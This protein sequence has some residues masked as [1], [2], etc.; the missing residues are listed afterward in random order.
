MS[1]PLL[2]DP[3]IVTGPTRTGTGNGTLSIDKLTHFTVAQTYTLTCIGKSPDTIFSVVASLDGPVGIATVGI[4]FFDQELKIFLTLQ[5]GSTAFEVG[6]QFVV[7]VANGT[8]LNQD[9]IDL[10]DELP[11][12]NFGTGI[13]GQSKGDHN[14]RYSDTAVAAYAY[15]QGLKFLAAT[16]GSGGNSLQIQALEPVPGT[17]ASLVIQDL[18]YTAL[19]QDASGNAITIEYA[20]FTPAV[21]ATATIQNLV[22]QYRTAGTTGNTS[23]V[24]YVNDGT[25]GSETC[26]LVGQALTVHIQSG[27][28]TAAQIQAAVVANGPVN[29]AFQATLTGGSTGAE[30][31]VTNAQVFL[32][33][34]AAAIGD[35]GNEV[36]QVTGNAIKVI[37]QNAASTASGIRTKLLA[38]SAAMALVSVAL[39][40]TGSNFE[41]IPTVPTHLAG[42]LDGIGQAG[43]ETCQV[44]GNLIKLYFQSGKSTATAVRNSFNAVSAATTLASC[45]LIG[46]GTDAMYSPVTAFNF[47]GGLTKF[48]A[49]NQH[50]LT[51]A[52]NFHEGNASVKTQDL[53]VLGASN[54]EGHVKLDDILS[55]T[56]TANSGPAVPNAQAYINRL[57]QLG[58]ISIRTADGSPV[59]Y[60]SG[61]LIFTADLRIDLRDSAVINTVAVSN[62]PISLT[63]GQSIYLTLNPS[64]SYNLTPVVA[65]SVDKGIFVLR[66]ATRV[67]SSLIWFNGAVQADNDIARI[68]AQVD[69]GP[70]VRG[71]ITGGG[72]VSHSVSTVGTIAWDGPIVLKQ[73]GS[74]QQ[75]SIAAGNVALADGDVAYISLDDPFVTATKTLQV[76]AISTF[77][78]SRVDRYWLFHR[79]GNEVHVRNGG[80]LVPGEERPIGTPMSADIYGFIGS[81]GE[82]DHSPAYSS[83]DGATTSN[84]Y[85]TDGDSLT[86]SIK[87]LD[88]DLAAEAATRASADSSEAST[89]AAADTAETAAR[90][91]HEADTTTHGTTGDIVGTS[92]TQVLT[93]KDID[94]GTASNAR[95]ITIPK[96]TFANLSALTRKQGTVLYA[97]DLNQVYYDD[98]TN[99]RPVG[100]GG[101][102][103]PVDALDSVSTTLPTVS[104]GL[105][106][107]GHTVANGDYIL[108]TALTTPSQNNRIYKAVI[109]GASVSWTLQT[110]GQNTDG[111]PKTGDAA[112]VKSGTAY[113]NVLF[114]FDGSVWYDY[115]A[116]KSAKRD[117]SNLTTTAVNQ[118]LLPASHNTKDLG[119]DSVR[120]A[121]MFAVLAYATTRKMGS[122]ARNVEETYL[123]GQTLTG[124]GTSIL[125]GLTFD[126]TIYKAFHVD[127]TIYDPG[128]GVRRTGTLYIVADGAAGSAGTNASVADTGAYTGDAGVTWTAAMSGNICQVSYTATSGNKTMH[129]AVKKF[130]G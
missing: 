16:A 88:T 114:A 15:L 106:V 43:S 13:K 5:Q 98:G 100:S 44:S 117:L 77:D 2:K 96:D 113:G 73:M 20:N 127:Y 112:Y 14:V 3:I 101:G 110:L 79:N 115:A 109:S 51:D 42:G 130:L 99:L 29:A 1:Q 56:E 119:S 47:S 104:T 67:G 66:L 80:T 86:K 24:Q 26:A 31:Q 35:A 97:T 62:S 82:T 57:M 128:T 49:F 33:G 123:D 108:F 72:T 91:A 19:A 39:T 76:A 18:T 4:Q 68:G 7:Q 40:G 37:A 41:T 78:L 63:D 95:R 94:G 21:K 102:L 58:K 53:T 38:S 30:T 54:F 11:Q 93:N 107:D 103:E 75:V 50:E 125:S 45:S 52:A 34:G 25:A 27:V 120:W 92:D 87:R 126:T 74:S 46:S 55:L 71:L 90:L 124:G 60:T 69:Y 28:T 36:V 64:Q 48:F 22:W 83:A 23:S 111:S 118:S 105:T 17:P 122:A 59:R 12:K 65:S 116:T 89:R 6:D 81:S 121:N 8:D 32:S 85:V 9:N 10:Y 61:S 84:T 129:A 70:H